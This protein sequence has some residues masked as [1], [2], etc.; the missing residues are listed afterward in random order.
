MA[1]ETVAAGGTDPG[2]RL[3]QAVRLLDKAEPH[4]RAKFG[5]VFGSDHRAPP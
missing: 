4:S 2:G 1:D 3:V 5:S